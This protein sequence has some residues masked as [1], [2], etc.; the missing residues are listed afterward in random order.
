MGKDEGDCIGG[1]IYPVAVP[2]TRPAI[3]MITV[4]P[5]SGGI[6]KQNQIIIVDLG[7]GQHIATGDI[8][9]RSDELVGIWHVDRDGLLNIL[10]EVSKYPDWQVTSRKTIVVSEIREYRKQLDLIIAGE[11]EDT[12]AD[13]K[14]QLGSIDDACKEQNCIPIDLNLE[15]RDVTLMFIASGEDVILYPGSGEEFEYEPFG[16]PTVVRHRLQ[17]IGRDREAD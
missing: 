5:A 1:G 15:V 8:E 17:L 7:K 2:G 10:Q 9:S 3:T 14:G 6:G 12:C 11:P 16:F 13:I 4:C